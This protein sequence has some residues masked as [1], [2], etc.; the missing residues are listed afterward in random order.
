MSIEVNNFPGARFYKSDLHLHTPASKCWKGEKNT[1]EL[2]KIFAKLSSEHI[3]V[4]AITDHNSVENIEACK[5]LGKT[6]GII[7]YPGTE[8]STKE[9]HVLSIFGP[10]KNTEDI[11]NWLVR[12]GIKESEQG[13]AEVV[14]K[15]LE[16]KQLSI[17]K[18][19]QSIEQEGGIA[20]APHPNS[21]GT[22]FL[23]ILKQ[24]G[25]ARMD[26]YNS[27]YL[28]GLE[29]SS[30]N[31]P[32][33]KL[34]RGEIS[35]YEKRYGCVVG[36]DAHSIEEIGQEYTYIKLGDFGIG[37]LKQVFY[38][39]DMRIRFKDE[40]PVKTHAWIE[41]LGVS[42]GFFDG[43]IFNFHPDMNSVVGG[44][45]V[46]KS[47][48][49]ELIKFALGIKSPLEKINQQSLDMMQART[50][51]GDGGTV[52]VYIQTSNGEEYRVQRTLSDLDCGPEVFY[53]DTETKVGY[54]VNK[55]F[56]CHIYSQNEVAQ[57]GNNLPALLDWLDAF[58]DLNHEQTEIRRIRSEAKVLLKKLDEKHITALKI[59]PLEEN[60]KELEEKKKLLDSKVKEPI[61]QTFPQWQQEE[62][63][64]RDM[65]TGLNKLVQDVIQPLEKINVE[66]YLPNKQEKT[67]NA[68]TIN[69][70][71]EE[72]LKLS[73]DF[74]SAGEILKKAV[75]TKQKSLEN[76]IA[77]WRGKYDKAKQEYTNVIQSAGV[78]NA[79]ALTSELDKC[80]QAIEN[81]E[82]EL[83]NAKAARREET[84][85]EQ[86]F[87]NTFIPA[88]I[89]CFGKIFEKR[90]GKA[91]QI[92]GALEF[93]VKIGVQQ[94]NDR[95][96]FMNLVHDI[97]RGSGL[98]KE[99]CDQIALKMTPV[100]LSEMI[101]AK[102]AKE[103]EQISG[104]AE[105]KASVFIENV[106][107]KSIDEEGLSHPSKIYQIMLTELKDTVT[108]EL[109]V[110]EGVYKPMKDLSGGSKCT[111]ILSV[112]L[113]EGD[114]PLIVDQPEDALD[115]PFVFERIVKTVRKT[116]S[117]RQYIFAT[118]NPN[119]AVASDA[120]L[121]YCL[122]ATASQGNIDKHGSID[123]I[124]TRDRVVA[125]L[126]GGESAFRLRS[127][128]YNIVIEDPN[129]IVIG[130]GK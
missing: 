48:L 3:E 126:E 96:E 105:N 85:L 123:N 83:N 90:L 71:R 40:Y 29:L 92:S 93:F 63:Q 32:L 64:L 21:R 108:V 120:D 13:N 103:F 77:G 113:V 115:N 69:K 49:I 44:K 22:G 67:P 46:G 79:S 62:R 20:I 27:P 91:N 68:S 2:E 26:A 59:K 58:L 89:E 65:Q 38:D 10:N 119:V 124:T 41:Y 130:M 30:N 47:L 82:R 73:T 35:G 95:T 9:G 81:T 125:N 15:D 18:V 99:Q 129:A 8:V 107:S 39:P 16:G 106:W 54:Q 97:A 87:F 14:A 19:F 43:T 101:I 57:L 121:I 117:N 42:Q 37:A 128:K 110:D 72:L 86:T 111:A 45:A 66:Q 100:K 31:M 7:I 33:L 114:Y 76:Y 75:Q 55:I 17:E 1:Q 4:V 51:L 11:K 12:I 84:A 6:K 36:S 116:K 24:K 98:R 61:L 112:A 52:I 127:Q 53:G 118:H 104:I 109:K 122:K 80:I 78:K 25:K 74:A 5:K 28:R 56:P 23:E 94:M 60:K 88:Y 34:A 50:C 70:E 102:N